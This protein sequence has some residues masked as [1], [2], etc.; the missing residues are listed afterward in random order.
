[1]DDVGQILVFISVTIYVVGSVSYSFD[2]WPPWGGPAG[3]THHMAGSREGAAGGPRPPVRPQPPDAP[4]PP[5]VWEWIDAEK[6]PALLQHP[7]ATT[8]SRFPS[9]KNGDFP[10]FLACGTES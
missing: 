4:P 9:K 5:V 2:M 1:M 7:S 3:V 6:F 10:H 8:T